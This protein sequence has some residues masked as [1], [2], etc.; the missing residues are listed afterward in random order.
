MTLVGSRRRSV[1]GEV[2]RRR[3]RRPVA[4]LAAGLFCFFGPTLAFA[5]GDRAVELENQRL[6][7]FPELF[8]GWGFIPQFETWGIAHLPLRQHAVRG[9]VALSD[10]LFGQP[11]SYNNGKKP[12]YPRVIEGRDGWLYFGDDVA[13]A[14]RPRGSLTET[15]DRVRRL[16]EI[17]RQSGRK[18]LF[19]VAPDKTTVYPDR[20][21]ERFLGKDCMNRR[22]RE[23]WTALAKSDLTGYIDLRTPLQTLQR[24]SRKPAYWR[25]DSHWNDRSAAL[26]GMR[27]AEALQPGL[28]KDSRLAEVGRRARVGDL[29]PLLGTPR[30]ETIDL[31][32]LTRDGVRQVRQDN[33]RMPLWFTVSNVS[34]GA[35]LFKPKTVLIG[36]SFT[37]SSV[38]WI[39]PYFADLT[40]LRS[41]TPAKAGPDRAAE[42]IA[43]SEVVVF[44]MVE[45]Y[46]LG[47]HGE[48]LDDATLVALQKALRGK[49]SS[50]Q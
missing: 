44:E 32:S 1:D 38:P 46:F 2:H 22:K 12:T 37:R 7:E 45:R 24:E 9:N 25:T 11:P 34:E 35:P 4:V 13:E 36:D 6:P 41:D 30:E 19:T 23:F 48:M 16:A 26:Y 49:H 50:A 3:F 40:V 20:L 28:T 27:L 5:V 43:A 14:C 31:W 8:Q 33:S 21:P 10:F 42:Q 15:L 47:G 39:T 17:V 18:F 29:G